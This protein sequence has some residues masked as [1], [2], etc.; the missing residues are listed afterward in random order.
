MLKELEGFP[1]YA[2]SDEGY[3]FNTKKNKRIKGSQKYT[4]Y[5]EVD[6]RDINGVKK[7]RLLHRI[8]ASNFC[9]RK[10]GENEV[11]HIDG[12]KTNN[13]AENLE[14]VAH[15]DNLKHAFENNLRDNDVSPRAVVGISMTNG[16]RITFPSIYQA[17][18]FLGISKGNIC[19]CCK[20]Q[21]P[22]ANGY[23]WRYA[24]GGNDNE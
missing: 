21:R 10:D 9:E 18:H 17:A 6:L 14:W 3:V 20:G 1:G 22:Y 16:E 4:G 7:S 12:D 23:Y 13:R 19:M 15:G 2:V 8:I 24:N 5:I 11:N